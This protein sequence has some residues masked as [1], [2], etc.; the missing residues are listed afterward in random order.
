[1]ETV[2]RAMAIY[3]SIATLASAAIFI[4]Y[5][6]LYSWFTRD[7]LNNNDPMSWRMLVPVIS[8]RLM[9]FSGI[10]ASFCTVYH[11]FAF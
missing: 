1:M 4:G 2:F 6:E 11:H 9:V 10:F 5:L 7:P 3:A 8:S